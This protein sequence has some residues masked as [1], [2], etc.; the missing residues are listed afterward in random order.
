MEKH[1]DID[2]KVFSIIKQ[3]CDSDILLS[4]DNHLINDL[5]L[6]SISLIS[7]VDEMES[8]WDI[9]LSES[10]INEASTIKGLIGVVKSKLSDENS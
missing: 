6:E 2:T 8:E 10:D 5:N 7:I 3:H 9:F 4:E 1:Q